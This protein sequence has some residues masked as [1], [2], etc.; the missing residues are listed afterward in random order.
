MGF[1][2]R[3]TLAQ[4]V[5]N[6]QRPRIIVF[7]PLH[8]DSIYDTQGQY[9]L[10]QYDFPRYISAPL[11]F[12]QGFSEALDSLKHHPGNL[13]VYI[14]DSRS[15]RQTLTTI[16]EQESIKKSNAWLLFGN[17][18]ESREIAEAAKFTQVPLININL[19]NDGGIQDNPYYFLWNNTLETQCE[20]IYRHWQQHY[21]L[22]EIVIVRKKGSIEDRILNHIKDAAKNTRGIPIRYKLFETTDTLSTEALSILLDSNKQTLLFGASLDE[23]FAR[24]LATTATNLIRTGYKVGLMGMSTWDNIREFN[25]NRFRDLEIIIP[26]PFYYP[27]TDE[28]SNRLQV[29]FLENN[30]SKP[31]DTYLRGYEMAWMLH[32]LLQKNKD[33]AEV[34]PGPKK[35]LFGEINWQPVIDTATLHLNYF[36]N[37]KIYFVKR[38]EGSV[39]SVR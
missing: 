34:L 10:K 31:S 5:V 28:W 15:E 39:L 32:A 20:G 38:M 1:F 37:K 24:N 6:Q 29:R 2:S 12:Y 30:Y 13:D 4:P 25:T 9:K 36:E 8:L 18:A 21:P 27:R 11:E 16:L 33:L 19:P 35:L 23:R 22:E 26:T 14:I 7:L 3:Q 17:A